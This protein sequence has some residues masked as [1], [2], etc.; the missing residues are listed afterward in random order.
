MK[1]SIQLL[2]FFLCFTAYSQDS[3]NDL[4][5]SK[6]FTD[7]LTAIDAGNLDSTKNIMTV[8][9]GESVMGEITIE[10]TVSKDKIVEIWNLAGNVLF[11]IVATQ[12]NCYQVTNGEKKLLPDTMCNDFK[13]FIGLFNEVNL[14]NLEETEVEEVEVNDEKC[15]SV[16]LPGA[17]TSHKFIYNQSTGLKVQE[18]QLTQS[19]DKIAES[20]I[21]YKDYQPYNDIK[22]PTIQIQT[23]FLQ[24]GTDVE[25][26]LESV[27]FNVSE[28]ED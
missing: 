24:T 28:T 26:K 6:V 22:F 23:N 27:E 1:I 14:K 5:G 13:P 25:F 8:Y 11:H 21:I 9:K 17:S 3:V 16:S 20:K 12:D 15:Y 18:I 7:Y 10:K 19:G 2:V 4:N